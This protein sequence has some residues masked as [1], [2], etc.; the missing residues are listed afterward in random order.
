MPFT[1]TFEDNDEVDIR[2]PNCNSTNVTV[3]EDQ[4]GHFEITACYSCGYK[5]LLTK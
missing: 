1:S 2:C 4:E 3:S 5:K